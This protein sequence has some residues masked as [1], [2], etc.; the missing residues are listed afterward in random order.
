MIESIAFSNFKALRQTT[1]PLTPFTLLLGPNGS[2]K[3]SVL[4]A[5]QTIAELP[6]TAGDGAWNY[7]GTV[8]LPFLSVTAADRNTIVGAT[9][10]LRTTGGVVTAAFKWH[11]DQGLAERLLRTEAGTSL[12]AAE[13]EKLLKWLSRMRVFSLDAN[14]I[15]NP[16]PVSADALRSNGSGLPAVLDNLKDN[17]PERW[18]AL[19]KEMREWL[20]EYDQILFD[21]PNPG[22]KAIAL[23]TKRGKHSIPARD[24]SQ[25][26]LLALALLS[27]AYS[28]EP[29]S[30]VGLEEI[31]RG[32]HPRLLRHL[33]DALYRLS[34][35]ES[36]QESRSPIQVIAT[37]HSPYLLDLY[38]EHPEEIV[39]AQKEGLEVQ[40]RRLTDI[41][42]SEEILSTSPLSEVWYSGVLGGA[43]VQ[44]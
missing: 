20:P 15:A 33:Q 6:P 22:T 36:C 43:S 19:L 17:Y 28:P 41:P 12:A 34:Y 26:T 32:L 39:L 10:R 38:R 16:V 37:T 3:T 8:F 18:E 11:A 7:G 31:D 27:L 40:M 30:V 42:N 9:L 24:L 5:L 14:Q 2:G 25:G 29:P 23:R 44:P 21:K 35:P 4:Q 13:A 1:L